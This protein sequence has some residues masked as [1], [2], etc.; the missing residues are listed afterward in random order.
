MFPVVSSPAVLHRSAPVCDPMT[1]PDS[2][3]ETVFSERKGELIETQSETWED[4]E[5][6]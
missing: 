4:E 5:Y 2:T 3:I 1:C 6:H